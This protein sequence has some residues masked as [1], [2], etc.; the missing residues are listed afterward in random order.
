MFDY[1]GTYFYHVSFNHLLAIRSVNIYLAST[2]F[3][4]IFHL[5][6]LNY[7]NFSPL[8]FVTCHFPPQ[9]L[10]RL[11]AFFLWAACLLAETLMDF[12]LFSS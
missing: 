12:T 1:L 7:L 10:T 9:H 3:Q 2:Y 5:V 11:S 6:S 8:I 4:P